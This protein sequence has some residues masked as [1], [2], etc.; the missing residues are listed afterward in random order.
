MN[1]Y[2]LL[3][4]LALLLA[5][6]LSCGSRARSAAPSDLPSADPVVSAPLEAPDSLN[7]VA[8][9]FA[10]LQVDSSSFCKK[11]TAS[12]TWK[13]YAA[14][15]D[16]RWALCKAGLDN[17]DT[18]ARDSLADI[19]AKARTVFYP[20]SGPDFVYPATLFPDADT[21]ITAALEPVGKLVTEKSLHAQYYQK[22]LP[23]LSTLMRVSYF[24]TK[25]MKDDLGTEGLGGVT[26]VLE[27]FI[28]RL[29]YKIL[30]VDV[31]ADRVVIRY[32]KPGEDRVKE[33]RHYKVNVGDKFIPESFTRMLDNLDPSTTVGLIKS[34]SY[35]MHGGSF[36]KIRGYMLSKTFAIVQDDTGPR[37]A[38]L[39]DA[40]YDVTLFGTY[41]HPI[42]SFGEYTYQKDLDAVS[43]KAPRRKIDFRFGYNGTPLVLVSRH[44][45]R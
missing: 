18:F 8:Y 38:K 10:G 16:S 33:L 4:V 11:Y 23:T 17:V 29:G 36:S 28:V 40:G 3:P 34:C 32:F 35:L 12:S 30:S 31:E 41:T 20:F 5:F 25:S 14:T 1:R 15:L 21:I 19:R 22:C 9:V 45:D 6:P 13:K 7:D 42:S 27:F 44:P 24:I 43:R 39:L 2:P 37:Y 26:P